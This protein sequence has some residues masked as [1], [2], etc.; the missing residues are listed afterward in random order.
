MR[1]LWRVGAGVLAVGVLAGCA[2]LRPGG[3]GP[4][5]EPGSLVLGPKARVW[6]CEA[7]LVTDAQTGQKVCEVPVRVK[8]GAPGQACE[9][10][11][12]ELVFGAHGVAALRWTIATPGYVFDDDPAGFR[13]IH[14]PRNR[15]GDPD[16]TGEAAD[17]PAIDYLPGRLANQ[18]LLGLRPSPRLMLHKYDVRVRSATDPAVRCVLDPAFVPMPQ[19]SAPMHNSGD[20]SA[21][22]PLARSP[23]PTSMVEATVAQSP[24]GS[25]RAVVGQ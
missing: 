7:H 10:D 5:V 8:P 19:T 9:I 16:E 6:R 1:A 17:R 21:P 22:I 3:A 4:V 11:V 2:G 24:R 13:G 15:L 20:G 12:P 23:W 18:F 25:N 14:L